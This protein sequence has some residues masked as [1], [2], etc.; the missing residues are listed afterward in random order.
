MGTV[1]ARTGPPARHSGGARRAELRARERSE[2]FPVAMRLL[3]GSVRR[4]LTA[5]YDVVRVIDDLGDEADGDRQAALE[6]FRAELDRVWSNDPPRDGIL[7]RLA[8]TVQA[9]GLEPEPFHRLIE[10][11][12]RDQKVTRYPRYVDLLEYCAL[13]ADPVGRLV[14]AIFGAS[15]PRTV[16]LSD[17]ICTALQLL[18][19]CQDVAEDLRRGRVYLPQ[20]DLLRS[21]VSED[22]LR[23][24]SASGALRHVV[25]L[26]VDRAAALLDEGRPLVDLLHGSARFAVTGYLAGGLATVDA[27]RRA[28]HD[29]LPAGPKPRRRDTARHAARLLREARGRR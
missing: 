28:G 25:R 12:L 21:G 26:Q 11:N 23:A 6:D 8:A 5:I 29:V 18:E 4:H 10:A 2:N 13:S 17:R 24:G 22:E 14:L 9:R 27:L 7:G 1:S 20:E 16:S 3:P 15:T 19:H